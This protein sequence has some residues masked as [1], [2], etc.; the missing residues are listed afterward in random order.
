MEQYSCSIC[1]YKTIRKYDY[2]RHLA[3]SKH[4]QKVQYLKLKK[5]TITT[6]TS[7]S[8]SRVSKKNEKSGEV[9]QC[10]CGRK[11]KYHSGYYRHKR[12]CEFTKVKDSKKHFNEKCSNTTVQPDIPNEITRNMTNTTIRDLN[13]D[14]STLRNG[15]NN[16]QPIHN[17]NYNTNIDDTSVNQSKQED[18]NIKKNDLLDVMK[19]IHSLF[20]KQVNMHNENNK[21]IQEKLNTPEQIIHNTQNNFNVMNYLN[22][23]CGDAMN[24]Y[25]F[26][27][28]LP[29]DLLHCKNIASNGYI[30]PFE[31]LF[32]N[33]LLD[34]E[35][36]KRPIHCTDIKRKSSYIKNYENKW[37][38]DFNHEQFD[39]ALD[40]LQHKQVCEFQKYKNKDPNWMD[41]EENLDFFNNFVHNVYK[42]NVSIDNEGSKIKRKIIYKTLAS[43]KLVKPTA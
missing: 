25:E 7:I 2:N 36:N 8:N 22:N 19:D 13:P 9:F 29:I 1:N 10:D 34:L 4:L 20:V 18:E 3:S 16:N 40:Y 32:I 27:D 21:L 12:I 37:V 6:P 15:N 35:Q 43:N 38:R 41:S 24:I 11:Y 26:I 28:S 30:Q 14:Q 5:D 17:S 33:A 39:N 42:M 31:D 23:E